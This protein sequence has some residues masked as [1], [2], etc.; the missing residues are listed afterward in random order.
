MAALGFILADLILQRCN[1]RAFVPSRS[2]CKE[3]LELFFRR[4]S[5]IQLHLR[6]FDPPAAV[7][8]L[9]PKAR[10]EDPLG[11]HRRS[12]AAGRHSLGNFFRPAER[13]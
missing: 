12:L 9:Y 10:R 11:A 2:A 3:K 7:C 6:R 1:R 13:Q 4:D 8:V 5:H